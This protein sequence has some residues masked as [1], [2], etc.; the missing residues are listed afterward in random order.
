MPN[1]LGCGEMETLHKPKN[2]RTGSFRIPGQSV[3]DKKFEE[4]CKPARLKARE[5]SPPGQVVA[6]NASSVA[7]KTLKIHTEP[8]NAA[9]AHQSGQVLGCE[10]METKIPGQRDEDNSLR[11]PANLP[12]SQEGN[13]LGCEK[14]ETKIPGQRDT[15]KKFEEPCKPAR[16]KA[17]GR[18]PAGQALPMKKPLA[19]GILPRHWVESKKFRSPTR[20]PECDRAELGE[21]TI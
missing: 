14:M 6:N 13:S 15:D 4:P 18:Q 16:L 21:T 17:R 5:K 8:P 20:L 9:K 12:K 11:S 2:A 19:Q 1:L 7:K 10:K 3:A